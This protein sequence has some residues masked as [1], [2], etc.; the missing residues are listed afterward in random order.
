M[1][2]YQCLFLLLTSLFLLSSKEALSQECPFD[3]YI[4]ISGKCHNMTQEKIPSAVHKTID[5]YP[6]GNNEAEA[7]DFTS[8]SLKKECSDFKY[9][10]TA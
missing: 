7:N 1:K 4:I 3:S 6:Y 9:Q 10:E 8:Q 2:I 5:R